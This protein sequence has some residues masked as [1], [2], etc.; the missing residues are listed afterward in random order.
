ML[1]VWKRLKLCALVQ[2]MHQPN[3]QK[4][5]GSQLCRSVEQ[6]TD[7]MHRATS[8]WLIYVF[9]IGGIPQSVVYL[10]HSDKFIGYQFIFI[11]A[12]HRMIGAAR[13]D[14]NGMLQSVP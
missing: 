3:R 2:E 1:I 14:K 8:V 10:P 5:H 13:L 9:W 4:R 7:N 12:R 11:H 6:L